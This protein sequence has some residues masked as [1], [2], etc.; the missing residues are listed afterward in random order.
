VITTLIPRT[1]TDVADWFESELA[2]LESRPIRV[3]DYREDNTYVLR[4]ELPGVDPEQDIKVNV[5]HGVLT[6]EAQRSEEKHDKHRTEFRY[7][8]LRRSV[9]LPGAADEDHISARYDRGV[10]EVTVPLKEP[11]P[12]GHQI[13]IEA[14]VT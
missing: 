12:Q 8:A 14:A 2:G 1:L 10:L 4:G 9:T 13:P 7:G 11:A 3:E 5:E 6:I